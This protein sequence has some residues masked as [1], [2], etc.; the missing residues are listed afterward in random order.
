MMKS[1]DWTMSKW[2]MLGQSIQCLVVAGDFSGRFRHST[3]PLPN[4]GH[5]WPITVSHCS[6]IIFEYKIE[7]TFSDLFFLVI[8]IFLIFSLVSIC[9]NMVLY[10]FVKMTWVRIS[11]GLKM[12]QAW[13]QPD[14]KQDARM[15]RN[16]KKLNDLK[17][18]YKFWWGYVRGNLYYI[19]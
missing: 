16:I 11:K 3:S 1:S 17:L 7:K 18:H 4:L 10:Q 12:A 6:Q 2:A 14:F 13:W 15:R 5:F 19:I 9:I 8:F